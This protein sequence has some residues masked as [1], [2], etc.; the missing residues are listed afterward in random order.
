MNFDNIR[1]KIFIVG[2]FLLAV[3]VPTS[4][5]GVTASMIILLVGWLIDNKLFTKIRS[6]LATG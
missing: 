6:F 3:A 5:T 4:E 1:R 2:L